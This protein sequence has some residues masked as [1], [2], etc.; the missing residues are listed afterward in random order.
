[1]GRAAHVTIIRLATLDDPRVDDYRLVRDPELARDR[2]LFVAEGRLVVARLLAGG[3]YGV[4]SLLLSETALLAMAPFLDR[5]G[6][7]VPVYVGTP[8]LLAAVVGH[9]VHRGCLALGERVPLPLLA[10]LLESSQTLVVLERV[11]NADNVGGVF[12]SA[13]AFGADAVL[14]GTGCCD[15]LYRKAIR[16]SMGATLDVPFTD[17]TPWPH[18]LE[19]LRSSGFTLVALTP[20][21][22]DGYSTGIE[23]IETIDSFFERGRPDRVALLLGSEGDGLTPSVVA[24][25]DC[26][27]RIPMV[28]GVDSLNVSVAAGI[29][30]ARLFGL[31][32]ERFARVIRLDG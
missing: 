19:M 20:N 4:R 9:D 3:R 14:C 7:D 31:G 27:I 12:R 30:L 5:L 6:R 24:L 25:A 13:L 15:P 8:A 23:T 32:Q 28:A 26:R 1:L 22:G 10:G 18:G 21:T 16:T 17:V 29:A 2:G 11:G